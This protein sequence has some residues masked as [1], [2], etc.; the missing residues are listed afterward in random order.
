MGFDADH[1]VE[2][3]RVD[4]VEDGVF[5][6]GIALLK[7]FQ[8]TFDFQPLGCGFDASL[9]LFGE[10]AG[11]ADELQV[12]CICPGNNVVFADAV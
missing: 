4:A 12:V 10:S 11:A 3:D 8:E 5:K 9:V 7:V 6:V 2:R 1:G